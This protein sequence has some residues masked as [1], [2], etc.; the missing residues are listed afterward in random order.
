M[1]AGR[2]SAAVAGGLARHI[3]VLGRQA[4][5]LARRARAA[6]SIS[7]APSAPAAIRAP[8]L[9]TAG[10]RVIGIDRDHERDRAR[11]PTWS[12][13]PAAGSTLVEDRFSNLDRIARAP[14]MTGRRRRARS[15][16]LVDAARRGRARLFVP[17]RRPARH[18]HGPRRAERRRHRGRASASAISPRS[19]PRSAKSA[20]RAR[21][22]ARSSTRAA[23]RRS[24]T[25]GALAEIVARVVQRARGAIHPATR[26][27][28]ALR[29][30]VN[31]EFVELARRR[32]PP[33]SA[34]SSRA[35]GLSWCR[36]I[37]WKTASSRP[38]SPSAAAR[39]AARAISRK[40]RRAPP[41][42][43]RADPAAGD[44]RTSEIAANPRARSAKLRAAERT[45]ARRA[46]PLRPRIRC[47]ACPRSPT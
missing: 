18:A 42:L 27:F 15:R 40:S 47:R 14:A 28:Q 19:S 41:T 5:E 34:F 8:I 6:A 46:Y 23:K 13:R 3:P 45:D 16:R 22:R 4:V 12:R 32:S 33:P 35:A 39:P 21:S 9:Q 2:D 30:F 11:A 25:T 10:A 20:T 44:A 37:R 24:R 36:S 43:P 7:T 38:S 26:T 29:I 1:M 17:P 31:D